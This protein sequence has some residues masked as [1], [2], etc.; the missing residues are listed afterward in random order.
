MSYYQTGEEKDA[1]WWWMALLI[2]AMAFL[3]CAGCAGVRSPEPVVPVPPSVADQIRAI[4]TGFLRY[5]GL[6]LGMGMVLRGVVWVASLGWIT[7]VAGTA[8]AW[9]ARVLGPFVG[10]GAVAGGL[11]VA[12]GACCVWMADYLVVVVCAGIAASVALVVYY[13]PRVRRWIPARSPSRSDK[14]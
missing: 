8:A 13:W 1:A 5:G 11:S 2:A 10:L 3:T 12:F 6:V 14:I 4:G 9:I 7:G